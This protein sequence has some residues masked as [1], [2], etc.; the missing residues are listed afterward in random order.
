MRG[1]NWAGLSAEW[2]LVDLF[3]M[4][5]VCVCVGGWEGGRPTSCRWFGQCIRLLSLSNSIACLVWLHSDYNLHSS[6]QLDT[7]KCINIYKF[8]LHGLCVCVWVARLGLSVHFVHLCTIPVAVLL[9]CVQDVLGV[10]R[11][12]VRPRLPQ[13][14]NDKI[15]EAHLKL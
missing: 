2:I 1:S 8:N 10:R 14:V 9:K 7:H 12:Q 13:R 4:R 6:T 15:Y 5:V 11:H 3:Y